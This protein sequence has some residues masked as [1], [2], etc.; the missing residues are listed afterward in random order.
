MKTPIQKFAR[1]SLAVLIFGLWMVAGIAQTTDPAL[2]QQARTEIQ[3]RGLDETE[4]RARLLRQGI[5]M[6]HVTP[7]QLPGLQGTILQVISEMEAEKAAQ[8]PT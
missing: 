5:D 3:R 6:D 7:E 1:R 2:L 4:V 8:K